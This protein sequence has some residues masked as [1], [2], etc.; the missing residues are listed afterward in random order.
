MKTVAP[1]IEC[2]KKK[3]STAGSDGSHCLLIVQ[4]RFNQ[5]ASTQ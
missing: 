5:S 2:R 3:K 4:V 1:Q